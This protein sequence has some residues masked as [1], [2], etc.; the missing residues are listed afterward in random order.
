MIIQ[1][2]GGTSLATTEKMHAI[3]KRIKN[4]K[5]TGEKLI[6]VVSAMGKTTTDLLTLANQAV[7]DPNGRDVDMLLATGEQVSSA[8]L[9]M[10]LNANGVKTVALNA[11]QAGIKTEGL[12][13]KNKIKDINLT[14][15]NKHLANDETIVITG[16]QGVTAE[17]DVA[18]LGRGGS[19]TSAVALAAKL[20][21]L[22]EIYTD[23]DGIYSADPRRIKDARKLSAISYEEMSE[24]AYLGAK[25]MEPRAVEI[26][27]K[28]KV[29]VYVSDAH[30]EQKGTWIKEDDTMLESRSITGL[31][32]MEDIV[33]ITINNIETPDKEIAD[34]FIRLADED[35]NIDMISQSMNEVTGANVSFTCRDDDLKTVRKVLE[36]MRHDYPLF[37]VSEDTDV[38]KV[39]VVGLGMRSQSGVAA[40]LFRLFASHRIAFKQVTTSEISIS[41]ALSSRSVDKAVQLIAE[42]FE[43]KEAANATL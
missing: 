12:F 34:L 25:V 14:R 32:V 38:T 5:K 1:K 24:L 22:C 41:Y 16:F 7:K 9:S 10:I 3:A 4:R 31:S 23:V 11:Y 39:S 37:K 21:G 36:Q 42:A 35:V 28:F 13:N 26:A 40:K 15:I 6:I 20:S 30:S 27:Q 18:T 19:D 8:L 33:M 43:L 29:P 17:G 2:Y